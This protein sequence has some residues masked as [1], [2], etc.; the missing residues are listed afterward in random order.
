MMHILIAP[1]AFKHSCTATVA[2]EAIKKG[3]MESRLEFSSTCFPIGDGGDGT[4]LLLIRKFSGEV[5]SLKVKDPLGR[6]INATLGLIDNGSTGVVELADASGLKLLKKEEYNPLQ[7]TTFGAGQLI[8]YALDKGVKKIILCIG[9]SATVDGATGIMRA[10]GIRFLNDRGE[11]IERLPLE[12]TQ[13]SSID[14]T[15]LDKRILNCEFNVLCDVENPLLGESGAAEVFGPQKGASEEQVEILNKALSH[16][17]TVVMKET[18]KNISKIK[19]G[20]AAGG[21]AAGLYGLLNARLMNGIEYFLEVTGFANALAETD[22]VITGEG[23][24]DAQTLQGKA[25]YGVSVQAKASHK[26]VIA[27]SG[28]LKIPIDPLLYDHF[29]VLLPIINAPV[30]LQRAIETTEENLTRTARELG[31]LLSF[32]HLR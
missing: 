5:V 30:D 22:I 28:Q 23:S 32:S 9:G 1:N 16:F 29:D 25:P 10:L 8:K 18:G 31:N 20:G 26:M 24:I 4:A 3:L 14:S 2:A 27:L 15:N 17:A 6:M 11:I 7:A 21:T 12:L 19:Y 13:L